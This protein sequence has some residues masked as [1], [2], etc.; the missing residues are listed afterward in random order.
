MPTSTSPHRPPRPV[1]EVAATGPPSPGPIVEAR[2]VVKTYRAGA[3]TVDALAGV[4]L[5]VD[6]GELV[7]IVG[8]SGSGKTTLLNCLSGLDDVDAGRVS[9]AG[10]DIQAMPD[11]ERTAFRGRAMGF[12]FQAFNLVPVFSAV[13]NVELPLL[14]RGSPRAAARTRALEVLSDVGLDGRV[15]HRPAELS[16]GQQQRVAIARALA[17][18]P[19]IVWTD[20]PTGSLDS[21]TAA[22]IMHLLGDLHAQ[23]LTIV[24][25][26]HDE[27]VAATADRVVAMRDGL[28][29]DDRV[30]EA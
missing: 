2:G 10:R 17:P 25:V 20:E 28:I 29:V 22:Q 23:G 9:V 16:G 11:R 7:A 13:E 3:T 1:E 26:T 14:L 24:L 12:I 15:D 30:R 19:Q 5:Q 6:A 21:A 8:P 27:E 18:R 4:D